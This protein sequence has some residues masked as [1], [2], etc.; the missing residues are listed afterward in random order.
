MQKPQ[1]M[2]W[3]NYM[4]RNIEMPLTALR[5]T[6]GRAREDVKKQRSVHDLLTEEGVKGPTVI[7][8]GGCGQQAALTYKRVACEDAT[9]ERST[10][11][12]NRERYHRQLADRP[13]SGIDHR[14]IR[15]PCRE[16]ANTAMQ[17]SNISKR[18]Q[19][20]QLSTVE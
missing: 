12:I 19:E 3:K 14:N 15:F 1:Y 2:T 8:A 9:V 10:R 16:D 11:R 18:K 4:W 13:G 17:A 5:M 6:T 20:A 7:P